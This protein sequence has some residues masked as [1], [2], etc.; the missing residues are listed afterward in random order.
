MKRGGSFL[1]IIIGL[2]IVI[3]GVVKFCSSAEENPYIGETQYV[4]L[5][6]EEEM[7]LGEESTP[8]M[9]QQYGGLHPDEA[10][11]RKIRK[12][13]QK[14]VQNSIANA[15]PYEYE[16]YLLADAKTINAFALPGGPV[17]ITYALYSK[18][19]S[20]DQLAGILGHEIGH[21]IG[22]HS[23]ERIAKQGF[24]NSVI[25]GVAVGSGSQEASQ[26]AAVIGNLVNMK[27]GRGDE[28]ESDNLGVK[29]MIDAGYNPEEMLGVMQILKESAGPNST[30]EFQSTHPDPENRMEKIRKA[31]EQHQ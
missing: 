12:I 11:Q 20:E 31:I 15:S 5:S 26:A 17:F 25:T 19:E 2:G 10:E 1:R 16:F 14:L 29:I 8:A 21:V 23:A 9:I 22:R 30:P 28:L 6:A 13:G 4:D 24:T 18:L 27:Y 3:F 7:A